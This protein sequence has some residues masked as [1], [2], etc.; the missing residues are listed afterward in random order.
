MLIKIVQLIVRQIL[1]V[2]KY[3]YIIHKELQDQEQLF[4][5]KNIIPHQQ[6]TLEAELNY[7][8]KIKLL[9]QLKE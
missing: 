2:T 3:Q 4:W 5:T 1:W 8:I 7:T 9:H 6:H